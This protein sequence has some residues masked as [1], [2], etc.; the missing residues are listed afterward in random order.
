MSTELPDSPDDDVARAD[1]AK[2]IAKRLGLG[3]IPVLAIAVLCLALGVPWWL[4]AGGI[5]VF[6]AII[7]FEA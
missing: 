5:G 4:V 2:M 7:L 6:V 1:A 3:A